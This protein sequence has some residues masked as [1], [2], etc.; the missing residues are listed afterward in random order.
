MYHGRRSY[1]RVKSYGHLNFPRASVVQFWPSR[2]IMGVDYTFES[3]V[4]AIWIPKILRRSIL[5]VSIYHGRRPYIRVK[6]YGRFNLS[7]LLLFNFKRLDISWA[8]T[9]HTSQKLWPFQFAETF[10]VQFRGCRYLVHVNRIS[11]W[12]VIAI[13]ISRELP[14]FNF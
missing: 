4:M 8:S 12:N 14:L 1:F 11:E 3:K 13:C 10:R 7:E 9:T 2:Y 5:S 6:S